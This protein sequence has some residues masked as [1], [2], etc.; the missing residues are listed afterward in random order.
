MKELTLDALKRRLDGLERE[1]RWMKRIGAV[2]IMVFAAMLIMGQAGPSKVAKVIE[3]ERVVLRTS[4]G[5]VRAMLGVAEDDTTF[6]RFYD[7]E[8]RP[9]IAISLA[10]NSDPIFSLAYKD[11]KPAVVLSEVLNKT[12]LR[13]LDRG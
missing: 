13:I 5:N 12:G 2:I 9:R 6:F 3:A 8:G 4:R 11:G 1:N 10:A 7:K